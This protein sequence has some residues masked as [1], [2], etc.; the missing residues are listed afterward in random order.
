LSTMNA[1]L[2]ALLKRLKSAVIFEGYT[3]WLGVDKK[4]SWFSCLIFNLCGLG[5]RYFDTLNLR[6]EKSNGKFLWKT[7]ILPKA[8]RLFYTYPLFERCFNTAVSFSSKFHINLDSFFVWLSRRFYSDFLLH[9]Q[10]FQ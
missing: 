8:T 2:S 9:F 7:S 6:N 3:C 5:L 1:I 10:S 4:F